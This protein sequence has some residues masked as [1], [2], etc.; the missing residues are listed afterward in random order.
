MIFTLSHGQATVERRFSVNKDIIAT[1]MLQRTIV[2]QRKICDGVKYS[3]KDEKKE[4]SD[5]SKITIT[6]KMIRYCKG[7]R[8]K[9]EEYLDQ[10]RKGSLKT[11][12]ET[13]KA[14]II[15]ELGKERFSKDKLENAAERWRKEA[16]ELAEKA[17]QVKSMSLLA[18]SNA[19][20]KRSLE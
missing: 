14:K 3:L 11:R 18:E 13:E 6:D 2:A 17:E 20:R 15:E 9:Y 1:N 7:A 4:N 10:E 19:C 5:I 16:D 8:I 12:M